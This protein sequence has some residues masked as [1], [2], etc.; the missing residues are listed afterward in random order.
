MKLHPRH[1]PVESARR[2]IADAIAKAAEKYD[3]TLAELMIILND[4]LAELVYAAVKTERNHTGA[5]R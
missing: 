4:K 2:E 5:R 3:L 1:V